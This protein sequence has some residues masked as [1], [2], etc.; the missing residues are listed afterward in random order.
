M[1]ATGYQIN[2]YLSR[3]SFLHPEEIGSGN[4][5]KKMKTQTTLYNNVTLTACH[6]KKLRGN[7]PPVRAILSYLD[8][9]LTVVEHST[10]VKLGLD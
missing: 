10:S 8:F 3:D 5:A 2:R 9:F 4:S 6:T 1:V 7:N